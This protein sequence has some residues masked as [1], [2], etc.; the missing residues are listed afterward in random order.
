ME[1]DEMV[2]P[3]N[4]KSIENDRS[5]SRD[6]RREKD[7]DENK[8]PPISVDDQTFEDRDLSWYDPLACDRSGSP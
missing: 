4:N 7:S 8:D 6:Y 3:R 5:H 1:E 2:P